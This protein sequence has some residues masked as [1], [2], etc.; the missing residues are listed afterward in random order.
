MADE[1]KIV[2]ELKLNND[3]GEGDDSSTSGVQDLTR[4]L[5]AVQHPLKTAEDA[6]LGKNELLYYAYKKGEQLIKSQVKFQIG[7]YFN[8]TENYKGE[9]MLENTMS[10]I[11]NTSSAMGSIFAGVIAGFKAGGPIGAAIGTFV[12]GGAA[13]G[14]NVINALHAFTQ[15]N[16]QLT[17][18]NMQ[19]SFQR[20]KLGL[21]DDGRGTQN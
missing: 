4:Y 5:N 1:R 14:T 3:G 9:Q 18:M 11:S 7:M 20:V 2:I 8:L 10:I 19:S 6:V 21:I 17:T 16:M 15:Q 13:F 12:G